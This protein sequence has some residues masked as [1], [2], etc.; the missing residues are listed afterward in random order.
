MQPLLR[1]SG[2]E[3]IYGDGTR[4]L[5]DVSFQI[6]PGEF[7]VILGPSG[8]GKT[9]LFRSINGLIEPTSGT[10]QLA[11]ALV[12]SDNLGAARIKLGMIFQCFD[13]VYNLSALN[14]V[15]TG[16]LDE[17]GR[18][19]SI[20]Y[21]FNRD[22]KLAALECLDQ[23]GLLAKA[24]TRVDRLSGGQQQR[25]GI[26]RAVVKRPALL[27][28]DEPVASLDP[29]IGLDI[30]TLLK[31]ISV[32]LGI[33]VLCSL[34][35]VELALKFADRIIGLV[36]GRIIMDE[37]IDQADM[38]YIHRSYRGRDRWIFFDTDSALVGSYDA[39][40]VPESTAPRR[41]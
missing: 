1:I 2:L 35:Q 9:T 11:G 38:A 3:T 30:L 16:L 21:S 15:L 31:E 40:L 10:V 34:H 8:S 29:I 39:A 36:D 4:A 22:K 18:Y 41:G 25:V 6:D 32:S 5:R 24:Y 13:L 17:C 23:V 27:L 7:V 33:T 12:R 19:S 37:P 26:A 14:N 20:F 28:A